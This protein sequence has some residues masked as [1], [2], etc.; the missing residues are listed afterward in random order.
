MRSRLKRQA[1]HRVLAREV[2]LKQV[3]DK[4]VRIPAAKV[5]SLVPQRQSLMPELLLRDLTAEQ[6][7]DLVEFLA[8]LR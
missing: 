3:G 7:A 2:V 4:E 8:G 6:A 1:A 5:A